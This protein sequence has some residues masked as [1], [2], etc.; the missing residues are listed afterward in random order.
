[1]RASTE[2]F[3]AESQA[4][5]LL[6][7]DS[8]R[9]ALL[10]NATAK[11]ND[12]RTPW[13][14]ST[15]HFGRSALVD[16]PVQPCDAPERRNRRI[17]LA[18]CPGLSLTNRSPASNCVHVPPRRRRGVSA[19]KRSLRKHD[20]HPGSDRQVSPEAI[21][22]SET[23]FSKISRLNNSRHRALFHAVKLLLRYHDKKGVR[24]PQESFSSQKVG[25]AIREGI[26]ECGL[27][28]CV[29]W[30]SWKPTFSDVRNAKARAFVPCFDLLW[31]DT[32]DVVVST[33]SD[34]CAGRYQQR[35]PLHQSS[36]L[37]SLAPESGVTI[38]NNVVEA[39]QRG[40]GLYCDSPALGDLL[41]GALES[42]RRHLLASAL[43][44]VGRLQIAE[45]CPV[46][47][48]YARGRLYSSRPASINMPKALLPALRS[49]ADL[50]L[51]NVDFSSF[52]LRIACQICG[53][54][55]AEGDACRPLADRCGISRT[56][57]KN[58][59]NPMLH[60]QTSAQLR[61][62]NKPNPTLIA[63]RR[64]VE[65]AMPHLLPQL[66]RGLPNLL[67]D[68]SMLQRT[69][70]NVFFSCGE[71]RWSNARTPLPDCRSM[72]GGFSR[73][74]NRKLRLCHKSSKP[75]LSASAAYP[76]R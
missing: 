18:E 11:E 37:V 53:Q 50:T 24:I 73:Q 42:K 47:K 61:H 75:K 56:R 76:F 45:L 12:R 26:V 13:G 14:N 9:T 60:C 34:Y 6:G 28:E 67:N 3:D 59:V 44:S 48:Q 43:A 64:R 25:R 62:A 66:T 10:S 58:I 69:G 74:P 20:S 52:E 5:V 30:D 39:L 63:D 38:P 21:K 57:A 29:D 68:K 40:T 33:Y 31:A 1:M 15:P 2:R 51:W 41:L 72:T 7:D 8:G 22:L 70:A 16:L 54:P 17:D 55:L 19:R 65:Q 35:A 23:L 71:P 49:V 36:Q 27:A 46:W 32:G 4:A